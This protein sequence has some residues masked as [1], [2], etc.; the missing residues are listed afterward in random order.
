MPAAG[1]ALGGPVLGASRALGA[2]AALLIRRWR[3]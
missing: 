2:D 3:F 1:H